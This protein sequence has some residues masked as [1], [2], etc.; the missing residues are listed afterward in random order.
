M[1]RTVLYA[2]LVFKTGHRYHPCCCCCCFCQ[3]QDV[4]QLQRN[5]SGADSPQLA[6]HS[7]RLPSTALSVQEAPGERQQQQQ[8]QQ[9]RHSEKIAQ[10]GVAHNKQQQHEQVMPPDSADT[11]QQ[12]EQQQQ[13]LYYHQKQEQA[14]PPDVGDTGRQLEQQPEQQRHHTQQRPWW[15][16]KHSATQQAAGHLQQQQHQQQSCPQTAG[17][18]LG[19]VS[20]SNIL[21]LN[22]R[23]CVAVFLVYCVTMSIFPG[24]LAGA[25]AGFGSEGASRTCVYM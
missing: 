15:R 10:T 4:L 8:Q 22:W 14:L 20:W 11:Q 17:L 5:L 7:P 24:F 2:A 1:L 9:Q 19:E 25:H 16:G 3:K 12:Q 6:P 21:Q 23:L 13:Q 18:V